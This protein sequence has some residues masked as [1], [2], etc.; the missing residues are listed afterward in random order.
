MA[1]EAVSAVEASVVGLVGEALVDSVEDAVATAVAEGA[2]RNPSRLIK[3]S[4][5]VSDSTDEALLTC[6]P[7]LCLCSHGNIYACMRG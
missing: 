5:N 7:F 3:S 6:P 2:K 1:E 4:C